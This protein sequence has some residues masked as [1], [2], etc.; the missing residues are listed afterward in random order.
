MELLAPVLHYCLRKV[1]R[2]HM[3]EEI[4]HHEGALF[5]IYIQILKN[6]F[7]KINS[8]NIPGLIFYPPNLTKYSFSNACLYAQSATRLSVNSHC[9]ITKYSNWW[10]CYLDTALYKVTKRAVNNFV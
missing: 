3:P 5:L 4:K 10:K 6:I 2:M 9:S 7:L 8:F 1:K